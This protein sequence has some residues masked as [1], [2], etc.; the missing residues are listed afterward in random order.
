MLELVPKQAGILDD[1]AKL[2]KPGGRLIYATCSLLSAENE[3]QIDAF[4]ARHPDFTVVPL[5]Q[6]WG[7]GAVPCAGPYL[8]LTPRVHD[9]DGFFG[10]VME[11]RAVLAKEA[12]VSDEQSV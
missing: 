6:V 2:V 10:A 11:R 3:N 7:E 5:E 9:T 1:A 4:L 12:K 8:S